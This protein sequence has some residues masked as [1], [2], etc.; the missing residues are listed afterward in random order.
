MTDNLKAA[1]RGVGNLARPGAAHNFSGSYKPRPLFQLRDTRGDPTT[2]R[3][4]VN[5]GQTSRFFRSGRTGQGAPRTST[6]MKSP[7]Q[8]PAT[9]QDD[10][11]D[12]PFNIP[13]PREPI[14]VPDSEEESLSKDHLPPPAATGGTTRTSTMAQNRNGQ[15]SERRRTGVVED[16][17]ASGFL[18]EIP[19]RDLSRTRALNATIRMKRKVKRV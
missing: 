6:M 2:F 14:D 11:D 15:V 8:S 5:N 17:R 9:F 18:S 7:G 10:V 4:A 3:D 19:T 13:D 1:T 16:G 12:D